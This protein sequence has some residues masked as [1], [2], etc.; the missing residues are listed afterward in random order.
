[1]VRAGNMDVLTDRALNR[2]TLARQLLLERV[3]RPAVE[4]IEHLVGMQAQAPLASYVGLWT[5][6]EAF[7]TRTLADLML[8]RTVVRASLMRWT[9]HLVSAADYLQLRPWLQDTLSSRFHSTPFARDCVGIDLGLLLETGRTMVEE[10]PL[11]RAQLARLLAERWPDRVAMSLAYAVT[12]LQPMVQVTPRGVWGS[13]GPAAWTTAQAWL[14]RP[15]GSPAR[16]EDL[17]V[18]YLGAFGPASVMDCQKWS[19]RTR[20]TA[21]ADRL[22]HQLRTFRDERGVELFDLVDAPRPGPEVPAPVRFLPEFDNVLLSHADRSR[23]LPARIEVPMPPGNGATFGTVLVDG[24]CRATWKTEQK[25][26]GATMA[27]TPF[28][29]LT[30]AERDDAEQEGLELLAFTASGTAERAVVFHPH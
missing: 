10:K 30:R 4:V 17:F 2:A 19:G 23:V 18:R 3:R 12:S 5:R 27:I 9:I 15:L 29:P 14:G 7:E 6:V 25:G 24:F 8:D 20:L 28:G 26:S 21:V 22:R 11:T 13:T 1:M 16:D